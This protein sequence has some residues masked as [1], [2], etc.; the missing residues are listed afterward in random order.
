MESFQPVRWLG[1]VSGVALLTLIFF[2]D[3][4]MIWGIS[5]SGISLAAF[6]LSLLVIGSLFLLALLVYWLYGLVQSSFHV[7]RNALVIRWG[8]VTQ[9]VPMENVTGVLSAD[10]VKRINRFRGALWPGL[11]VGY[12]EI[13]GVGPTLFFATRPLARQVILITPALAYAL[14]PADPT[15]FVEVVRQRLN[16]GP[17]QS[18]EQ[19]SRQPGFLTWSFWK[20]R[21]GLAL[22][23]SAVLL[24]TTLFGYISLRYPSLADLQPLHFDVLGQPD[25]W[26]TRAQVFTLPFIGLLALIANGGVGF[27]L[28]HRERPASYL[29]WSG[30]IGVQLLVWGATLGI[31]TG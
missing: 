2:L 7:D 11:R 17:S 15:A 22:L 4:L 16:M 6:F 31:L 26:G 12:G 13:E 8:A 24:L 23:A 28:Y 29:L 5:Q 18:V 1:L 27:L 30:A 19:V 21:L 9:V 20:D 14:S 10:E 3:G 25:R